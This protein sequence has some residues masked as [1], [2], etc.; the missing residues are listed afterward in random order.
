[1]VVDAGAEGDALPAAE[2]ATLMAE[3]GLGG[4]DV[5]LRER[6]DAL[7]RDR[8][9][10]RAMPVPWH[11]ARR[12]Y[13]PPPQGSGRSTSAPYS[14]SP[15]P[16]ASPRPWRAGAFLLANSHGANIDPPPRLRA[17]RFLAVAELAGTAAQ[18]RILS[19]ALITLAEIEQRFSDRIAA[20]EEIAFD[21]ASASLRGEEAAARRRSLSDQ[22]MP[23]TANDSTHAEAADGIAVSVLAGCRGPNGCQQWRDRVIF[24]RAERRRGMA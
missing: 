1:M 7:R 17:S 13:L 16:N 9:P 21:A 19:A 14:R 18:G 20:R 5:D 10:G 8:S 11:S 15:T 22:P 2:V 3:R 23:V 6:L 12:R 4:D 24:L